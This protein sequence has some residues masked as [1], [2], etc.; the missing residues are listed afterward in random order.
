MLTKCALSDDWVVVQV[1]VRARICK[2]NT[3]SYVRRRIGFQSVNHF[4]KRLGFP[5]RIV[6]YIVDLCGVYWLARSWIPQGTRRRKPSF[7]ILEHLI[8]YGSY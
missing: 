6:N 4:F 8:L 5:P 1:M 2:M 7:Q 3:S